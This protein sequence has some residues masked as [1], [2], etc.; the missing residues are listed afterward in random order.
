MGAGELGPFGP[1]VRD[2]VVEESKHGPEYAIIKLLHT[3]VKVVWGI[4]QKQ[5]HV[6]C[7]NVV[8][9]FTPI[10]HFLEVIVS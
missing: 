7:S 6:I 10:C 3:A 5:R 2:N 9:D 1:N 8:C 4:R